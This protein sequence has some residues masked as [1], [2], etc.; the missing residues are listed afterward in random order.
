MEKDFVFH[1]PTKIYFGRH[2][3]THL[4]DELENYGENILL[5]YGGGSIKKNGI[6]DEVI[7]ALKETNKNNGEEHL[8]Y[9]F[10]HLVGE[11]YL[12]QLPY[13]QV[14]QSIFHIIYLFQL[15]G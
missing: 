10:K 9:F 5:A 13:F 15:S 14:F 2:A 11:R 12:N 7:K 3:M 8:H 6:Y 4:K 1:N